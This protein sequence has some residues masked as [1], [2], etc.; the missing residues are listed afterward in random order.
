MIG[1]RSDWSFLSSLH[2]H[3][4]VEKIGTWWSKEQDLL[5]FIHFTQLRF[6]I[7]N[8]TARVYIATSFKSLK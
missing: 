8:L 6:Y 3:F 5:P 4:R 7:L 1:P 2:F